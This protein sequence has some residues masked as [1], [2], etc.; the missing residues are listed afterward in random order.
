MAR[1]TYTKQSPFG[2]RL[3]ILVSNLRAAQ[4]DLLR[5]I[6]EANS[7]TAGG[8]TPANLE[9]P[10]GVKYGDPTMT[11]GALQFGVASGQGAAFYTDLQSLKSAIVP[12]GVPLPAS[13]DLD[14][15]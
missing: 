3:S 8:T 15:G 7:I 1:I 11:D 13:V 4:Y 10:N 6:D 14:Q 5:C 12:A 9:I 2:L